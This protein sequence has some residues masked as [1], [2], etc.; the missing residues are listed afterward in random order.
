MYT[1]YYFHD[2]ITDNHFLFKST[3]PWDP[4]LP[5]NYNLFAY[6]TEALS[7]LD[8]PQNYEAL[9][10]CPR[11]FINELSTNISKF[12]PNIYKKET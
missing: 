5:D 1:K 6:E 8:N 9:Q 11:T 12:L 4:P 3:I 7:Q 2:Y 10:P